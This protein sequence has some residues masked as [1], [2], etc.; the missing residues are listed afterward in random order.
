MKRLVNLLA[1]VTAIISIPAE[2]FAC[3]GVCNSGGTTVVNVTVAT[4]H[5]APVYAAPM[6]AYRPYAPYPAY[7]G[8]GYGYGGTSVNVAVGWG[9]GFVRVGVRARG[10]RCVSR[11]GFRGA[12]RPRC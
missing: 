5:A 9:G 1:L 11:C 7:G 8:G 12:C 3:S 4:R 6:P 2:S 10:A